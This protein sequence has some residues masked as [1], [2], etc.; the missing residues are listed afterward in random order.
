MTMIFVKGE[1]EQWLVL[2]KGW[3]KLT[4]PKDHR[5]SRMTLFWD[6]EED[7]IGALFTANETGTSLD[8]YRVTEVASAVY[9]GETLVLHG[10]V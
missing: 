7:A 5:Q 2:R 4:F 8:R 1:P 10:K 9:L 6:G 3:Y